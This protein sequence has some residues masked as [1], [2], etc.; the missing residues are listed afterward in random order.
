M[1]NRTFTIIKPNAVDAGNTGKI[2]DRILCAGFKL[3]ALKMIRMSK[4]QAEQFYA[5][6]A[7]KPFWGELIEFMTSGTSVVAVLEKENAVASLRRLVGDTDPQKA[8]PGTIRHE[9]GKSKTANTIHASDSNEN[10]AIEWNYFFTTTE[11]FP[12]N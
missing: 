3:I 6:H 8:E 4:S 11:I 5:H 9:F 2:L 10:A 7:D 1:T 12:K